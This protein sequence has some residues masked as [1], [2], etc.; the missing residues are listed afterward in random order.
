MPTGDKPK[1][2]PEDWDGISGDLVAH[3]LRGGNV[4]MRELDNI[5]KLD[6]MTSAE[7]LSVGLG[8]LSEREFFDALRAQDVKTLYDLRASE[9]QRDRRSNAQSFDTK[10]LRISCKARG[11]LYKA[12]AIGRESAYGVL[13]H[14][15]SAEGQHTLLEL[16]WQAQRA[17][18]AFLG[19]ELDWRHDARLV[20]AEE[21]TKAGHAVD[22]LQPGGE[23]HRHEAGQPFPDWLFREEEKLRKI[24]KMRHAGELQRKNKS[25]VDRSTESVA[26]KLMQKPEEVDT[27][28]IL[29]DAANQQELKFAQRHLAAMQRYSEKYELPSKVLA[30]TPQFMLKEARLQAAWVEEHHKKKSALESGDSVDAKSCSNPDSACD[31]EVECRICNCTYSWS[32]L[33]AGDGCCRA[34]SSARLSS[35]SSQQPT[36]ANSGQSA[37]EAAQPFSEP[38][39]EPED[40]QPCRAEELLVECARCGQTAP[41][42][43]LSLGDGICEACMGGKGSDLAVQATIH[44]QVSLTAEVQGGQSEASS[45]SARWQRRL[46]APDQPQ[47]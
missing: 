22:H 4:Q 26:F 21:L 16:T 12:I 24:E 17:R 6:E 5:I 43:L 46:R 14:V 8:N 34:C 2:R 29:R 23:L 31:F 27:M 19:S 42:S 1:F 11:I 35:S 32:D 7:L 25:A 28:S 41:W 44:E 9:S 45:S 10:T 40:F 18:T 30:G 37:L 38:C 47:T 15:K 39:T 33:A 36:V 13:A 3:F 20:I